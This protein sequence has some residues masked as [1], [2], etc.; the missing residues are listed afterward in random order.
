[1]IETGK[2]AILYNKAIF[3][4]KKIVNPSRTDDTN[5]VDLDESSPYFLA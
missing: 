3:D 4:G 1:L 5:D 2:H